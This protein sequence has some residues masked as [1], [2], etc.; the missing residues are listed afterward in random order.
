MIRSHPVRLLWSLLLLVLLAMQVGCATNPVSGKDEFVLMSEEQEIALG[1][2]ENPKIIAEYGQYDDPQLQTYVQSIGRELASKSHRRGLVYRFTVLDSTDVNAFALPGGYIYITRGLLGYL[3]SEAQ[4]AAVLGHEI[5]HVTARHSVRQYTAN[6]AAGLGYTI[7]AILVPELRNQQAQDLYN[8]VSTAMV[9]GYGREHELEADRLGAEYLARDGYDPTAMIDVIRVLKAQ[10][11]FDKQLAKEEGREPHS[12]H[13]LFATHP[14]NDTRLQQVVAEAR[15]LKGTPTPRGD[16]RD[17]FLRHTEGL[18]FGPGESEG[19]V[20]G[21]HFYHRKLDMGLTF[22]RG[23][24]VENSSDRLVGIAPGRTALLQVSVDD[25]NKR[26][27]PEQFIRERLK[28]TELRQGK[29]FNAKRLSG[30]VGIASLNTD[31]G[32]RDGR[33]A[34]VYLDDKA[35]VFLGA[36]KDPQR[37]S[38]YDDQFADVARSLHR[39]SAAERKLAEPLHVHV[40]KAV[41]GTT[42]AALAATSPI[43]SHAEEQLRLL[44]ARYPSGEPVPGELLKI[45]R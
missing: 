25:L 18:V 24:Q 41:R 4:L 14:D 7:G 2:Q 6:A 39:L 15:A 21:R 5:G 35:Y 23:W 11:S 20:R 3:N 42:F 44:N 22:P 32:Q 19:T 33:I 8:V 26:I 37:F 29:P 13:G 38:V 45:V 36:V 17:V 12:Y 40:I 16:G 27:P 43:A 34:A 28:V 10:E 1:R 31:F 9:R 30:Y